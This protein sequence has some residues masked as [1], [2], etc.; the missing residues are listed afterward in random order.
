MFLYDFVRY[1]KL[2]Y[3]APNHYNCQGQIAHCDIL[4][5]LLVC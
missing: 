3:T 5:I 1:K 2:R 4:D